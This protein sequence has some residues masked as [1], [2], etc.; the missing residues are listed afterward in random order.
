[1]F[2]SVFSAPSGKVSF[3]VIVSGLHWWFQTWYGGR[4]P[5][6]PNGWLKPYKYL[7]KL[8]GWSPMMVET[9]DGWNPINNGTSTVSF[10]FPEKV[11]WS[12][13]VGALEHVFYFSPIV[14]MVIQSDELIFF[15]GVGHQW[16]YHDPTNR[17]NI[18]MNRGPLRDPSPMAPLR[19][20]A[21][22]TAFCPVVTVVLY[23]CMAANRLTWF[24][25]GWFGITLV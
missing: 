14:G 3:Q 25:L 16:V 7:K 4:N 2:Q 6:P 10:C 21:A 5:A 22:A 9:L 23:Q 8:D 11:Q 24:G 17:S 18:S 20:D 15:R 13:L 1:L 12:P 19:A